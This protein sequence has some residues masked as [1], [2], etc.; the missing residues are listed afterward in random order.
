MDKIILQLCALY[1]CFVDVEFYLCL[2][3]EILKIC[4]VEET[5]S[6]GIGRK[7]DVGKK[8]KEEAEKSE[9]LYSPLF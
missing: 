9:S 1:K 7:N 4:F 8:E 2:T 3:D 6:K 5:E